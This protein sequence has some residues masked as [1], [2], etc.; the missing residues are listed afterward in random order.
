MRAFVVN[1]VCV[2]LIQRQAAPG[3][4][5]ANLTLG[6]T[7]THLSLNHPAAVVAV[8]ALEACRLDYG[9]VDL[10]EDDEGTILVLEVDAWAGFSGISAATGEDVAD[11][12]LHLAITRCP[13]GTTT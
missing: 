7:S 2:A 8:K 13:G 6:A 5:R 1:G 10:I 4:V 9:G 3:E 12:I 11:A